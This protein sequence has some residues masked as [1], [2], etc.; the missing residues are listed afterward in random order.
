M[1]SNWRGGGIWY[2]L[3]ANPTVEFKQLFE[4]HAFYTDIII[5]LDMRLWAF[6]FICTLFHLKFVVLKLRRT[7]FTTFNGWYCKHPLFVLNFCRSV[8]LRGDNILP[9]KITNYIFSCLTHVHEVSV[10]SAV[11][12]SRVSHWS[13][14]I[15]PCLTHHHAV[16][17]WSAVAS[18]WVS[19][20]TNF[21][22]FKRRSINT[23]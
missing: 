5:A 13:N 9:F 16:W 2:W 15:F 23:K 7:P 10:W 11:A 12:S 20:W 3:N 22:T 17:V 21:I 18:S 8:M 14:Y 4:C 19:H 1:I 6:Y